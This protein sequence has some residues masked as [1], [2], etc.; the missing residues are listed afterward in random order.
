MPEM[1]ESNWKNG[2]SYEMT[3]SYGKN[4]ITYEIIRLDGMKKKEEK[5][6][7]CYFRKE[8]HAVKK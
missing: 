3:E 4:G 8:W 1:N 5:I 2:V 7:V 6:H